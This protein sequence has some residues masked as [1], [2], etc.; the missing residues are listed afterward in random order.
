MTSSVDYEQTLR[1]LAS[2]AVPYLADY[3][4]FDLVS[5]EGAITRAAIAHVLPEKAQLA[6]DLRAHH[7]DPEAP[8]NPQQVMRTRTSVLH[9][10][11]SLTTWSSR[12]RAA[13]KSTWR[14]LRS[15]GLISYLCVPMAAHD[16][17]LGALTLANGESGRHFLEEDL[18]V[19]QDLATRAAL[20]WRRR[21]PI[22]SFSTPT[23]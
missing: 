16:R 17:A 19:A 1:T 4:A 21:S 11:R 10:A 6:E 12:E 15:L 5:D 23:G 13:M 2:L 8:T 20:A 3:C 14:K 22:S 9:P 7:E 18:R